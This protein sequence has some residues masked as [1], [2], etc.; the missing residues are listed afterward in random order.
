MG[1]KR[2]SSLFRESNKEMGPLGQAWRP[3]SRWVHGV[4]TVAPELP[5]QGSV[6]TLSPLSHLEG[7]EPGEGG[8]FVLW[9]KQEHMIPCHSS[10]SQLLLLSHSTAKCRAGGMEPVPMVFLEG[11]HMVDL[12]RLGSWA[13]SPLPD[14]CESK[15]PPSIEVGY[16]QHF[17]EHPQPWS[18]HQPPHSPSLLGLLLPQL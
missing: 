3:R 2:S 5:A 7:S 8:A 14:R 13:L 15:L 18:G 6:L 11:E 16:P 9:I 10:P 4:F 1:S 12:S 17:P